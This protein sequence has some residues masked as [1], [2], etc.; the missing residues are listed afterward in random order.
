VYDTI[1]QL[2]PPHKVLDQPQIQDKATRQNLLDFLIMLA[3]GLLLYVPWLSSRFDLNGITEAVGVEQGGT[4][5]FSPN[6]MLYRPLG[7]LFYAPLQGIGVR[8]VHVLQVFTAVGAAIGLGFAFLYFSRLSKSRLIGFGATI[9][10]GTTWAYW[11]FSTD[12]YYITPAA[13]VVLGILLWFPDQGFSYRSAILLGFL[14][15]VAILFWQANVFL[16]LAF[17]I[18]II[19]RYRELGLKL[20]L[21]LSLIVACISSGLVVLTYL[22]IGIFVFGFTN[23]ADFVTWI[24]HYGAPLPMW[25][26]FGFDRI[27]LAANSAVSSIIPLWSGLGLQ[28]LVHGKIL[29]DKIF[30]QLSLLALISLTGWTIFKIWQSWTI[31]SKQFSFNMTLWLGLC[32]LLFFAF[33]VWWD[34][35]EP[36]WS[37]IPNIFLIAILAQAWGVAKRQRFDLPVLASCIALITLASFSATVLP[38]KVQ[39]DHYVQRAQCVA[40]NTTSHDLIIAADWNWYGYL[41][42]FHQRKNTFGLIDSSARHSNKDDVFA[43]VRQ[44]ITRTQQD[45]GSTYMI[46]ARAY[47]ADYLTW[48][49]SQ[50]GLTL[51]DLNRFEGVTVFSCDGTEFQKILTLK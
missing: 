41:E 14:C 25:G 40:S 2:N 22:F 43:L 23:A 15:A 28:E 9:L 34:P 16:V 46:P 35:Y 45:G 5:L 36:K 18:A 11:S 10:M 12:V 8:A 50:T 29:P 31:L 7:W 17:M 33:I 38:N 51:E 13:A 30:I 32:Y 39:S 20:R 44:A 6:H 47:S 3:L 42:Y 1:S 21:T 49:R 27:P 26:K 4:A 19:W 24:T 37:V 48:L